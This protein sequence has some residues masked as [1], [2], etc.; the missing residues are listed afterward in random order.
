MIAIQPAEIEEVQEIKQVLSG[1]W[2]DTYSSF[3][4]V[5]VIHKITSLWHSPATLAAEIENERVL[6]NVAKNEQGEIIGLLTA[7]RPSD[8]VIYIARLYVLPGHQRQGVGGKLLDACVQAFP[9]A[10]ILRLEVE[11]Q[12]EKGLLFYRKQGF[13]KISRKEEEL[14]GISLMVV[15]MEKRL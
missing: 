2:T 11:E 4:P 13:R 15:G 8:E 9:G 14:E 1:T 10:E 7:N 3:L 6:F 12:N 5:E